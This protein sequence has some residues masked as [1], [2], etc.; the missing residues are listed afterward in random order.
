MSEQKHVVVVGGSSGMGLAAAQLFVQSGA[1]ITIAGRSKAKLTHAAH[2]I[3]G[4]VSIGEVDATSDN[5]VEAFFESTGQIDHLVVTVASGVPMGA[6]R[7]TGVAGLEQ[8][9]T[10]KLMAQA[11]LV[12][13]A[14]PH[15]SQDSSI[16]FVSGIAGRRPIPG[17]SSAAVANHGIEALATVLAKELAPIRVNVIAPGLVDTPAYDGMPPEIKEAMMH[18]TAAALPVGRVGTSEDI[19]AAIVSVATNGFVTGTTFEIDG[20][21][22][23]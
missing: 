13:A 20:G 11:R 22:H 6:F 2:S 10:Y 4:D 12:H 5:S 23:L 7:E 1:R 8:T 3:E 21:A 14:I 16:T 15:L 19:G 18:D 9:L 17:M